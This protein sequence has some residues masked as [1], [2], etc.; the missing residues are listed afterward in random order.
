MFTSGQKIIVTEEGKGYIN[1]AR[2]GDQGAR[3]ILAALG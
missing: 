2:L 1:K 3:S